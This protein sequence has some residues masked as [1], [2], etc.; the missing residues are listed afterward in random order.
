MQIFALRAKNRI[1]QIQI[2]LAWLKYAR[3][4]VYRGGTPTFGQLGA[5]FEGNLMRQEILEAGVVS[6]KG[7]RTK[8]SVGGSGEKQIE[9][10]KQKIKDRES[11]LRKELSDIMIRTEAQRSRFKNRW[12]SMP[13]IALVGYTNAGKTAVINCTTGSKLESEDRLFQTLN[14]AQRQLRFPDGQLAYMLDTVGFITNLPHQLVDCFKST[15]DELH[16]ADLLVHVRDISHPQTEFQRKTVLQVIKEVGLPDSLLTERYL[17]VWNKIDL[18]DDETV[19][20]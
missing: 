5:M 6:A 13:I 15:L 12:N 20:Q 9:L 4:H 18:I 11:K 3:S 8:G 14:T 7:G 19:F 2:E 17:E 10:E 1:S 16:N